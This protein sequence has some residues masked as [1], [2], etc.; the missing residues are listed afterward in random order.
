M[1]LIIKDGQRTVWTGT[2][3]HRLE[4]ITKAFTTLGI[5]EAKPRMARFTD[6]QGHDMCQELPAGYYSPAGG[7]IRV[8]EYPRKLLVMLDHSVTL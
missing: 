7:N 4:G 8:M 2:V 1:K 5:M 6:W 3:H